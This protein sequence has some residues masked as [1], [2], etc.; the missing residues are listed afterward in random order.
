M[1]FFKANQKFYTEFP[2]LVQHGTDGEIHQGIGRL[3]KNGL[4]LVPKIIGFV[5]AN[6]DG[7]VSNSYV[8]K[9]WKL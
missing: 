6:E 1:N 7:T 8:K 3:Y 4:I 9:W 2:C 5:L